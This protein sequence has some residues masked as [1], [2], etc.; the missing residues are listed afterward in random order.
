[1]GFQNLVGA[2]S[3]NTL[4]EEAWEKYPLELYFI[5]TKETKE[6]IEDDFIS[7][8]LSLYPQ[9]SSMYLD[10]WNMTRINKKNLDE[11]NEA[12]QALPL[13]CLS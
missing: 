1:M 2:I 13:V 5:D 12:V 8:R 3:L 6:D 4:F 7:I 9:S 10:L 11:F